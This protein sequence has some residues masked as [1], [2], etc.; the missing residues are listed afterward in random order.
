VGQVQEM[1][2][3][4]T[5]QTNQQQIDWAPTVYYARSQLRCSLAHAWDCMISYEAWNPSFADAEVIRVRGNPREEGGLVLIRKTIP[6][7]DGQ[8]MLPFYAETVK[9]ERPRHFVWYLYP[10]DGDSLRNFV[11]FSLLESAAGGVEF[12]IQY[13]AQN[14]LTVDWLRKERQAMVSALDD[15]TAALKKYA[16]ATA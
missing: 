9:V 2:E 15:L 5:S 3:Q 16:E 7:L 13:Y 10:K 4:A 14:R 1:T 8:P 6:G 12:H 11:D